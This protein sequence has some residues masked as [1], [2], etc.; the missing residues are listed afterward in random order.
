MLTR[1][2]IDQERLQDLR[3]ALG[4]LDPD[5]RKDWVLEIF[6]RYDG[7][8]QLVTVVDIKTGQRKP[9]LQGSPAGGK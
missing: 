1:S 7:V 8:D 6:E 9:K 5:G 4:K 2:D 3:S